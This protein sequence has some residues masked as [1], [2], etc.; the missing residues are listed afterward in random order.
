M[1]SALRMVMILLQCFQSLRL[2]PAARKGSTVGE[3]VN[4]ISVDANRFRQISLDLTMFFTLPIQLG[5]AFYLLWLQLG[6]PSYAD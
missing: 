3:M 4:L 2:S 6:I 1:I 5:I